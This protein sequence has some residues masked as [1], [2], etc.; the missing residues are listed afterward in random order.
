MDAFQLEIAQFL[1]AKA[2]KKSC[3]TYQQVGEAVGWN[4]PNGR[5]LGGHLEIILR[6]LADQ[7]LPPGWELAFK[8]GEP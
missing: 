7:G 3:A 5:G 2:A 8:P 6:D 1:A 4:H